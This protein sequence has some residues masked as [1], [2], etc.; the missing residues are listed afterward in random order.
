MPYTA[1]QPI[2]YHT[3]YAL[4][5]AP[6]PAGA[7]VGHTIISQYSAAGETWT[8]DLARTIY[9]PAAALEP[10]LLMPNGLEKVNAYKRLIKEHRNTRPTINNG[11]ADSA[12]QERANGTAFGIHAAAGAVEFLGENYPIHFTLD[13]T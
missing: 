2:T 13:E 10:V 5:Q 1:Y 3:R 12:T 9:I 4:I 6:Q 7:Y 11:T 8:D